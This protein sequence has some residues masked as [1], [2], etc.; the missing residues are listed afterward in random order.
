M[1]L[2]QALVGETVP[3]RE[4]ARYQG[5]LAANAVTSSTLGPVAADS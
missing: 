5:Y 1:T 4:R 3:P 2:S